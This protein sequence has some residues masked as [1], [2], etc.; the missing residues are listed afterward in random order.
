M[1]RRK[2]ADAPMSCLPAP[3]GPGAFFFGPMKNLIRQVGFIV[4]VGWLSPHAASLVRAAPAIFVKMSTS[5]VASGATPT[6]ATAATI[7]APGPGWSFSAAAPVAGTTWNQ[8]LR[9][10]PLI[11]S[12]NTSIVGQYVCNSANNLSLVDSGG[13]ATAVRLTL[14]LDIQDLENNTTRT[15]PNTSAGGTTAAGPAALMGT[16][17]RIYRGGNG[18]IH[19]LTG[20]P[21]NANYFLYA[22]GTTPTTGQG[23]KFIVD[24][25]NVPGGNGV[26]TQFLEI[27]GGNSGNIYAFDGTNYSL[28]TPAAANVVSTTAD[29]NSWGRIHVVVDG[30]GALTFKTAK[31]ANNGQYYQGYQL[32][33]YPVATFTAQPAASTR[34]TVGSSVTITAAA[35]GEGALTYQWRKG[36][37]PIV[38]GPSGT[39]STYSG[40]TT[41]S[42]TLSGVTAADAGDYTIVVTNPGGAAT[43]N[44]STLSITTGAI[45]PSIVTHPA[46]TTGA[47]NGS[48]GFSVSANGTSPLS[49]RWQKSL[50][51]VNFTDV[52]G[53][54]SAA[55]NL[56][57][58]TTADAGYYRVVVTNSVGS[59]TSSAAPLVVAP[60]ITTPPATALV[61]AGSTYTISVIA[62][63][64]AG[65]PQPITYVWTRDGT[66][67][68]NG[69]VVS[70][71]TTASLVVAGFTA[72]QSGYYT[73]TVSNTAGSVTS[74][75]VYIGVPSTQSVTFAPGNNAAG[76]AI[77]QQFRLVFPAPP[78]LGK[79]GSFRIHDASNDAVVALVN[80][81]EFITFTLF[82]ATVVNAK[83]Q[84]LQGK[85]VYHL[86]A[87]I[88]GNEVWI[89]LPAAGRLEYGK[90]Y[91][92]TMDAGFLL[93]STNAAVPAIAGPTAWRFS[94]KASGP[95]TPT[96]STGPTEVTVGADGAGDFATIQGAADW[97]PQNNTLPRTIRVLPGVYRDLVYFAQ[98]RNFVT[99]LGAG[100][101]RQAVK[102][103]YHYAAEVYAGGARGLGTLRIDSNDVTVRNL[104]I[105]D[106]VYLPVSNLAGGSNPAAPAFAGPIQALATTG[107]R[108]VFDNVLI[109]GGQD[110][111]YGISG[112]AYFYNCEMWGSVDF[113]YGDALAVFDQCD[114]VQIR[115]TGGPIC[116]P[117][118]PSA[119]PYGEVFLDCRFP[120]ALVANGYPYD[121]GVN[122]T[123][124]CR[125]W[126]QD[127]HVAIINSQLGSH[128]TTKAWS[129]WDGRENT[130]RA[131]EYGNTLV[132]GGAAP[133]P[134]QRRAAGA[135]W[136]NTVDPD[137]T[138]SAMSPIDALLVS[139]G[140]IT[141]RTVLT[142][143]PADYTLSA[144]FGHAYFAADLS[145][146]MPDVD[147]DVAPSITVQPLAKRVAIGQGVVF[148][149]EAAGSP[150]L[151]YQWRK[152]ATPISGATGSS[153]SIAS[154]QLSHAG[155][156]DCVVTNGAGSATS[157]AVALTALT[158]FALWA[159]GFG[160]DGS[161]T[162]FAS[163]DADGDGVANLLEYVLGGNPAAPD[164]GVLPSAV[165]IDTVDGKQLVLEYRRAIAAASVPVSVETSADLSS[166]TPR[167]NGVDAEIEVIPSIGQG[168]NVDVNNAT[169]NNYAGLAVAPGSGT[170][171]NGVTTTATSLT[172]VKD[173]GGAVTSVD[174]AVTSSG[175]FSAWSNTGATSGAPNPALLMQDYFFGNTYTITVSGLAA[176]VYQLYVYAHGDVD[177][178]T[179]T[180]TVAASNGGGVKGT[181]QAGANTFRDAFAANAEG[182]AYVRFTPTVSATG[183][184]QFSS[185]TYL[186][187]F[188]LVQLTD[189]ARETVRIT[190]PY[191]GGRL[192]ARLRAS[193]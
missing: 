180:V 38:D 93:D 176:G 92:V 182:V 170:V 7:A 16:A 29:N 109:R 155:S 143:D 62:D 78:K 18:S 108:L 25:A 179:S 82:S 99:L 116:A 127:G 44:L 59:A 193:E 10:N 87:A 95:A 36:G 152:G 183:V 35:T 28:T 151:T 181:A 115:N 46:S 171:W 21:A 73:V 72:A 83:T 26:S 132:G 103:L 190:L 177:S 137:Y 5:Q 70:G 158:P 34:A 149:V 2:R 156:Y 150:T 102:I 122:T 53:A 47:V 142:I 8:V 48:A 189:P 52:A 81:A 125:P 9:P 134:A 89:T 96:A 56:S 88:Y 65:S 54:T 101:G 77:D 24:A 172:D 100:S 69:G 168:V 98:N 114:I 58:L 90:T 33:P 15:E 167:T 86:P 124:F 148:S 91:Y 51:N 178:Q 159:E 4:L 146:W 45:A 63:A 162:G 107:K 50:N 135:Y 131:V 129:E 118:T 169:A 71:A 23:C 20:L 141:N 174:V 31:N 188:Q 6:A 22:Y 113:I 3:P 140:G 161:A 60:V 64:G 119:Q 67:V 12:N 49:Y 138:S 147:N 19:K 191:A 84:T 145:G 163:A 97:I 112:I 1:R 74:A 157:D 128:I 130:S 30:A 192:F 144:I 139:P 186:N 160:L 17:W 117:S 133:T 85:A 173:S 39:G 32:M 43:S 13:A 11:G 37:N 61:T 75:S 76:L 154:V 166:W 14:S 185:A 42:L 164:A 27:R 187:G 136:L 79:S 94:T 110:T 80:P 153:Y 57:P 106:E 55:L 40:A 68:A 184:L 126:R 175:G 111:Y 165:V 105:D 41:L 66:V 120:R 121:V 104:T 123:T